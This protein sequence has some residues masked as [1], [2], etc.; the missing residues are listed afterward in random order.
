M[1]QSLFTHVGRTPLVRLEFLARGLEAAV[2]VKLEYKNLLGSIKDRAAMAMIQNAVWSGALK[3]GGLVVEATSGNTG[4]GLA[5]V[6]TRLGFRLLLTMPE[7]MS[8]ERRKL[9]RHLGAELKL[10]PAAGGM[11]GAVAKAREIVANTPG[12]YL[13][14]QFENPV[15]AEVHRLTTGPEIW[16]DTAGQVDIF[17][18][19]VGTGGTVTGV[20]RALKSYKTSVRVLAVEPAESPVLSGG[21][22]GPHAIQGIGAGFVPKIYDPSVVDGVI[23]ISSNAALEH[24]RMLARKEGLLA[25][26]SSGA[27]VCAALE[28]ARLPENAGKTIVTVLPSTGERYLST[29]LFEE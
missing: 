14:Q 10:T 15:V 9:L 27:A 13:P 22:P 7:N 28:Q 4:I 8:Q 20:G 19:G 18:A 3:P 24:G 2:W 26:I 17:I 5:F 11:A 29:A 25:G 21:L 12:A 23:Q 6:C 1:P 16:A